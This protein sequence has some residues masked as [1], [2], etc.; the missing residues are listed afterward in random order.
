MFIS[1]V[2]APQ[3][4]NIKPD[5][6]NGGVGDIS[7]AQFRIEFDEPVKLKNADIE[8][9]SCKIVKPNNI[10]VDNTNNKIL[11]R[12]GEF[13]TAVTAG[14]V[15]TGGL[16]SCGEQYTIVVQQKAYTIAELA[17][18]LARKLNKVMPCNANR[19][20]SGGTSAGK[21]K[22]VYALVAAPG[23]VPFQTASLLTKNTSQFGVN[24]TPKTEDDSV[25]LEREPGIE[26]RIA[27]GTNVP[28]V[29][30]AGKARG[31]DDWDFCGG[32]D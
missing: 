11:V 4:S 16:T 3:V 7:P 28:P 18:E 21:I 22:L 6:L 29:S 25:L 14:G 20:W 24:Q 31:E 1:A 13:R 27:A 30:I 32:M 23:F 17:D 2:S 5:D 8:L 26:K 9:V 10:I 15:L 12:M 19:G